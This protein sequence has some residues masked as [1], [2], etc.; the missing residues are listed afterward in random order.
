MIEQTQFG[1]INILRTSLGPVGTVV[2]EVNVFNMPFVF[3]GQGT[4]AR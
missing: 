3:R 4:C 2:P 1:A